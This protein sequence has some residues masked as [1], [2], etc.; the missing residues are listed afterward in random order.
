MGFDMYAYN[1]SDKSRFDV[2][3]EPIANFHA[4]YSDPNIEVLDNMLN[5]LPTI[6]V[7][8][9]DLDVEGYDGICSIESV[10]QARQNFRIEM[11]ES[12]EI[13]ISTDQD[14]NRISDMCE[15]EYPFE[16]I[17]QFLDEIL[18]KA[19]SQYIGLDW[20]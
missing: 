12:F 1:L 3:S 20:G 10:K 6:K 8:G 11:C 16:K 5:I 18:E 13:N 17:K 14:G 2:N 15:L 19:S 9:I 7:A 4:F